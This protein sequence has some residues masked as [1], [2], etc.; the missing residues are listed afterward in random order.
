M[1]LALKRVTL[2]SRIL[3]EAADI[4]LEDTQINRA[5]SLCMISAYFY[6]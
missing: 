1:A 2:Y 6:I 5:G 3:R 4:F